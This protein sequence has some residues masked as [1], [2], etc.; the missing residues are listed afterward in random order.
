MNPHFR[1]ADEI[2]VVFTGD[3][4]EVIDTEDD[5]ILG[6]GRP[7]ETDWPALL[8]AAGIPFQDS[9]V[10]LPKSIEIGPYTYTVELSSGWMMHLGS[11]SVERVH[12]LLRCGQGP[13]CER[14]T[15]LHE[16]L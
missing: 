2:P 6:Y 5:A 1:M 7:Q 15:V 14:D 13:D 11:T 4:P 10:P 12:I 9:V 3:P 16:V 8:E